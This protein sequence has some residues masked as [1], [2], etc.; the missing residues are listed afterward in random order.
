MPARDSSGRFI[1][2]SGGGGSAI[3]K[4]GSFS[5]QIGQWAKNT[6]AKLQNIR[7]GVCI[8][9]F[10][11]VVFNTAVDTGRL[12][13][14]WVFSESNAD[15]TTTTAT[16]KAGAGTVDKITTGVLGAGK[17][18]TLFLSNSLPYSI[19][20][21][22]G[23]WNGPTKL[24]TDDGFSRTSPRG[25]VRINVIRFNRLIHIQAAAA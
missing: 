6:S 12:R 25:A 7:R 9:L 2:G 20:A 1:K 4:T 8:K 22:R 24:V 10:G 13:A 19:K 18:T 5:Q 14:N 21:E 17:Y 23:G 11:A 3:P 15:F 16:D